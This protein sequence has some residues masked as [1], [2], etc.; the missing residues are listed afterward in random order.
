MLRFVATVL[1]FSAVTCQDDL[2]LRLTNQ[3]NDLR[4]QLDAIKEQC[5]DLDPLGGMVEEDGYFLA[6]KVFAGNGKEAFISYSSLWVNNDT[7]FERYVTPSSCR[8][9]GA[10]GS[11]FRGNFLFYWDELLVD[12]VKVNIHKN[13]EV[14][15]YSVFNGTGST[16]L[17][18]F[19]RTKLLESSWLDLKT[20][21]TNVFSIYGDP[22]LKRQFYISSNST[23]CGS[24]AGWLVIKN[25]KEK[26]SWGKLPKTAKYPVIFFANPNHAVKFSSGTSGRQTPSACG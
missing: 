12:T 23:D 15:H 17:N 20:S 7:P 11:N 2:V 10:C 5:S 22:K 13:G 6:F 24:D 18:W 14:V 9:T 16:Y 1:L 8:L 21:S 3:L 26:C 19:N 4:A 25:S